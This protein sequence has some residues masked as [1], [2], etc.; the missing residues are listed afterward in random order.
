MTWDALM[1]I[2]LIH[3]Q[4]TNVTCGD[5]NKGIISCEDIVIKFST[6]TV[7]GVWLA[8]ELKHNLLSISQ[9]C[10]KK[11][12][13]IL[14]TLSFLIEH[15]NKDLVFKGLELITFICLVYMMFQRVAHNIL[16]LKMKIPS[17]DIG[18]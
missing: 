13:I 12:L 6:I 3:K 16:S 5:N 18:V 7:D 4:C 17:C 10:D 2:D 9:S 14:N 11:Y 15:K 1:F 8:K